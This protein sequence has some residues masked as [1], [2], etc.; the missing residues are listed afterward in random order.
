MAAKAL[1]RDR[2]G[3]L[4][5]CVHGLVAVSNVVINSSTFVDV[6]VPDID[7]KCVVIRTASG[8]ACYISVNDGTTF[9]TVIGMLNM[10]ILVKAGTVLFACKGAEADTLEVAYFD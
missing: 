10:N 5:P 7:A 2:N 1:P 3:G 6:T 4:L 8:K 9:F